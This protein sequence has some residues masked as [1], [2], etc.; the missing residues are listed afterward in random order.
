MGTSSLLAPLMRVDYGLL[1]FL[2]SSMGAGNFILLTFANWERL[3][4]FFFS[5]AVI[6]MVYVCSHDQVSE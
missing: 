3:V 4:F 2:T 5:S 6:V 1:G